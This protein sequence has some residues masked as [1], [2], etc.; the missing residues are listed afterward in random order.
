VLSRK[1]SCIPGRLTAGLHAS[2]AKRLTGGSSRAVPACPGS[3]DRSGARDRPLRLPQHGSLPVGV[4]AGEIPSR[5]VMGLPYM[6]LRTVIN[7]GAAIWQFQHTTC[8]VCAGD[9]RGGRDD[10]GTQINHS[11]LFVG[12]DQ[13]CREVGH[14]RRGAGSIPAASQTVSCTSHRG[15]GLAWNH[16]C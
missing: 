10:Y 15:A 8:R 1:G 6:P 3:S 4:G 12:R 11:G 7:R 2:S 9:M 16:D 13:D 14:A 5:H